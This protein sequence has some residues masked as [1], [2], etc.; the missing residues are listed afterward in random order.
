[1]SE[2]ANGSP[3]DDN[4]LFDMD[5]CYDT[6]DKDGYVFRLASLVTRNSWMISHNFQR[7]K[8]FFQTKVTFAAEKFCKYESL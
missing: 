7:N 6:F 2:V 1:M 4:C 3:L 5:A 8:V